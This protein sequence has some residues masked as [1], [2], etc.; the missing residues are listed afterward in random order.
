MSLLFTPF[1]LPSPA[2]G[3]TLSNR[4]VVAPMCQYSAINGC[5]TDWH[6]THWAN[7]LNSGAGLFTLEATAVSP[8]AAFRPAA[9]AWDVPPSRTEPAT[10][11]APT[12]VHVCVQLSHAG[13]KASSAAPWDNGAVPHR[14]WLEQPAGHR[15]F[16]AHRTCAACAD[17]KRP[18]PH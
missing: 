10:F 13:R 9:W 17:R 7:L 4:L 3:L 15:P 5:A 14:R 2:G 12:H 6:L 11:R 8:M 1:T 18:G 16:P